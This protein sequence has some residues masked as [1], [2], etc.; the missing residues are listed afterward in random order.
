MKALTGSCPPIHA[1]GV[2]PIGVPGWPEW[3]FWHRID[4]QTAD[5]IYRNLI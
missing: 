5:G 1:V 4:R 3:A 2:A